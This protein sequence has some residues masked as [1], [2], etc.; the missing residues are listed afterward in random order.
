MML[1]LKKCRLEQ[2]HV[3]FAIAACGV[4]RIKCNAKSEL[5]Q[6]ASACVSI[7]RSQFICL[8]VRFS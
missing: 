2:L 8:N 6:T 4:E 7:C 3:A 5:F 1:S